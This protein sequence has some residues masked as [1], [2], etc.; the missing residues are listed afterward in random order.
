MRRYWPVI[1]LVLAVIRRDEKLLKR[2]L[3]RKSTGMVDD[4]RDFF[5]EVEKKGKW[6]PLKRYWEDGA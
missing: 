5:R 2:Y 3:A 4:A 6:D 1:R